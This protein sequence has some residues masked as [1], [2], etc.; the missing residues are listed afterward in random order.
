MVIVLDNLKASLIMTQR[1][2]KGVIT[3]ASTIFQRI[4]AITRTG[5][6]IGEFYPIFGTAHDDVEDW[7]FDIVVC[8]DVI[9]MESGQS[10]LD[11]PVS[12]GNL[13]MRSQ[14]ISAQNGISL[15]RT[16][17][18]AHVQIDASSTSQAL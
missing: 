17:L 14:V 8:I 10:S 15:I 12:N 13:W 16:A 4:L 18:H 1:F 6:P 11:L 5:R 3:I 7:V 9:W 2:Q